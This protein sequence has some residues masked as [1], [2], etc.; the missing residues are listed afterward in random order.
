MRL[1]R[2]APRPFGGRGRPF[3]FGLLLLLGA[4]AGLPAGI[5]RAETI[6]IGV[7]AFLGAEQSFEDWGPTARAIEAGLPG[8]TVVL[9][10][11]DHAGLD[12]AVAE[13]AVDYVITNPGHYVELEV[14]HGVS[15][16]ATL[17]SGMPVASAIMVRR[18]RSDLNTLA[19]LAGKRVA[20][21]GTTAFGGFQ[22]AW[23]ELA[24]AGFD[25]FRDLAG[26]DT[27]GFPMTRVIDA[28]LS[29]RVDAGI[30]RGCLLEQ[31]EAEGA[32]AAGALRV[33]APRDSPGTTCAVSSRVYPDWP[34]AKLRTTPA[35]AAK[36]VATALLTYQPPPGVPGWTV[37]LDYQPVHDAF[38][39]LKIGPYESLRHITA[40]E[41]LARYWQVLAL[42]GIALGAWAVHALRVERLVRRRTAELATVNAD[43]VREIE[44]RRRVEEQE[45]LHR[46]EL[47]HAARLSI[48]GEMAGGMAHELNQPLAA[49]AN[50]ADGCELRLRTTPVDTGA[51]VHATK[52][53]RQQAERAAQVIQ[54]MRAF[55]RKREPVH[56]P[57]DLDEVVTEALEFFEG[58]GRRA[59]VTIETALAGA[60]PPVC[61]D[62]IQL[63]QV[64]LNLLQNAA[65]ASV[66]RGAGPWPVRVETLACEGGACV[67]VADRGEGMSEEV[68][69]RL[70][71]PFF[72]T[73]PAGLGLGLA[74][75]HSIVEEHRGRL[76]AVDNPG[77]GTVM[78]LWLPAAPGEAGVARCGDEAGEAA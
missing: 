11:H 39:D 75:C 56:A 72:T 24:A 1:V 65:D 57:V 3:R 27:V 49:I 70:F 68:K 18:E 32:F 63:Q 51:L 29:N 48:L 12:R 17:D 54:R 76:Q 50:Y 77:G 43:L 36:R 8:S 47:D 41:L 71:E 55:V 4:L 44:H 15:R 23:R 53:I 21:V 5:A 2:R 6:R 38:R 64:I 46:K 10:P 69:A 59:G 61:G 22:A 19:D 60:L 16:I 37:P 42:A 67:A 7:L 9:V 74:L 33:L 40:R 34:I 45:A 31:Q 78:R 52:L 26:L 14:A 73:K 30:L 25:P 58:P 28:V 66:G 62:R 20:I 13:G 35:V